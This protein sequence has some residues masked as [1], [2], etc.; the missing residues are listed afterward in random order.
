MRPFD[1]RPQNRAQHKVDVI[2]GLWRVALTHPSRRNRSVAA[3]HWNEID[4]D[5]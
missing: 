5:R 2:D 1:G 3:N 4:L